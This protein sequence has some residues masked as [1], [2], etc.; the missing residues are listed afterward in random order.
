[1]LTTII[2]YIFNA[3]TILLIIRVF[4]SWFPGAA[5]NRFILL[6]ALVTDPY[7]NLFRR[8]IPPI[9]GTMDISPIVAFLVLRVVYRILVGYL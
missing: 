5:N 4:S 8:F 7:L 9:G 3:Y 6:V 2:S 1:M